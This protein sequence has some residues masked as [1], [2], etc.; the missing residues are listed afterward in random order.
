MG[1][2]RFGGTVAPNPWTKAIDLKFDTDDHVD[3]MTPHAKNGKN[4]PRPAKG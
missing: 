1:K 3:D 4:R 2:P